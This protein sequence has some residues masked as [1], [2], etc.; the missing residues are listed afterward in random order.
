[1]KRKIVNRIFLG[2]FIGI[3][4]EFLIAI[5]ISIFIGD[6]KLY[7]VITK[8]INITHSELIAVI[9]QTFYCA[10][11]GSITAVAIMIYEIDSWSSLKKDIIFSIVF[12]I[13]VIFPVAYF[14]NF[15]GDSIKK[16][17][18]YISLYYLLTFFISIVQ[19]LFLKNK[20]KKI[21]EAVNNQN[22][23]DL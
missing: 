8:L 22:D 3:A 18:L 9:L 16:N 2:F 11:A 13:T 12:S 17:I 23:I 14:I 1:M 21:N 20:I 15:M 7:P 4:I 19:N 5:I 6:G 10:M